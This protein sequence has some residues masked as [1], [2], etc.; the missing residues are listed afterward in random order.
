MNVFEDGLC[1]SFVYQ[2]PV[3]VEDAF[4]LASGQSWKFPNQNILRLINFN[5]LQKY[6]YIWQ[7]AEDEWS[8]YYSVLT[9]QVSFH[10]MYMDMAKLVGERSVALRHK[11]GAIIVKNDSIISMGFNG[12]PIGW[13]TNKCEDEFGKTIPEVQHAEANA[14]MKIA[15]GTLSSEGSTIYSTLSPC[16]QCAKLIVQ[17]KIKTVYFKDMYKNNCGVKFL[18]KCGIQVHQISYK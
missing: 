11:V 18:V 2:I 13:H 10:K 17:A 4:R 12:T 5:K 3:V 6:D 8:N 1:D 16:I 14:I 7:L 15:C 9:K